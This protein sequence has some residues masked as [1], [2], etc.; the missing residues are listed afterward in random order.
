MKKGFLITAIVLWILIAAVI[1]GVMIIGVD[2]VFSRNIISG[3]TVLLKDESIQI[4]LN[5]SLIIEASHQDI[6]IRKTSDTSMKVSHYGNSDI[7][8]DK[9]FKVSYS[10]NT[11]RIY[12]DYAYKIN[13]FSL[14]NYEKLVVEIPQTYSDSLKVA[15]SSGDM[16]IFDS[17]SFSKITLTSSSG[18]IITE[19]SIISD[20]EVS[21]TSSSGDIITKESISANRNISIVS[22]SGN[23]NIRG[24]I[25]SNED[26]SISSSSGDVKFNEAVTAKNLK[27]NTSSGGIR[28]GEINIYDKVT[29]SNSSGGVNISGTITAKEIRAVTNSGSINLSI[30]NV[31][32][33]YLQTS[34][35]DIKVNSISGEGEAKSSSGGINLTLSDPNGIVKLTTSSGGI[36]VSLSSSLA[37]TLNA[38]TGSGG[39]YSNFSIQKNDRGNK[40]TASIGINPVVNI[41]ATASSGSIRINT[42]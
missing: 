25:T 10:N 14:N 8:D 41:I 28:A 5:N 24:L 38:Q 32:S 34:S 29:F 7:S 18:S 33:Y 12:F 23:I 4:G 35:G 13:F 31:V 22:S 39:I 42:I 3:N 26:I 30:V 36:R 19:N 11:I 16:R 21:F 6:E 1:I 40:A 27:I 37:F 9:L 17:F 20:E 15:I 2:E